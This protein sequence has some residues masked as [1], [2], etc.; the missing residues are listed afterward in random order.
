M[1]TH[2][3][4]LWCAQHDWFLGERHNGN[5]LVREAWTSADDNYTTVTETTIEWTGSFQELREW[6][7]Y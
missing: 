2:K 5:L 7:G 4:I 6:A 3:Q 1:F